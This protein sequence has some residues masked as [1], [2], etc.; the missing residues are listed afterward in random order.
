MRYKTFSFLLVYNGAIK[1]FKHLHG[2]A[3]I[4]FAVGIYKIIPFC[5]LRIPRIYI[6]HILLFAY[7]KSINTIFF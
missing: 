2:V 5:L 4:T 1:E 3:Y 6:F 7:L